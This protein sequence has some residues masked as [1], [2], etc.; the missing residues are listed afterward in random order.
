V[1]YSISGVSW[2]ES[3]GGHR[4]AGSSE[5][6]DVSDLIRSKSEAAPTI[7]S[8]ALVTLK[9]FTVT[10]VCLP[11]LRIQAGISGS[12]SQQLYAITHVPNACRFS[13]WNAGASDIFALFQ[14]LDVLERRQEVKASE[15]IEVDS[16]RTSC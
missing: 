7:P 10:A 12:V 1:S 6:V 11:R 13:R 14:E 8:G 9:Q 3:V 15:L 2:D 4:N 16:A 5:R